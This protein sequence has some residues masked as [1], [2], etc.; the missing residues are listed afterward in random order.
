MKVWRDPGQ[1]LVGREGTGL[2]MEDHY[3]KNPWY[4][5]QQPLLSSPSPST[6]WILCCTKSNH[7]NRKSQTQ[8]NSSLK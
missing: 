4:L 6:V 8:L 5:P 2:R 3:G 7:S 1:V